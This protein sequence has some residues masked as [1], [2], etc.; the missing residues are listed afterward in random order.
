ML[1]TAITVFLF[2]IPLWWIF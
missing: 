1:L 2:R